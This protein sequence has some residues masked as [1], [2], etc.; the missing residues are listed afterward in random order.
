MISQEEV[1]LSEQEI[2]AALAS[3][4][5]LTIPDRTG[6]VRNS[7]FSMSVKIGGKME[8]VMVICKDEPYQRTLRNGKKVWVVDV[9]GYG[10]SGPVYITKLR[11]RCQEAQDG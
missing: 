9:F 3:S 5:N 4:V 2:E 10:I 11:Q 8:M 7:R 1:E 6:I